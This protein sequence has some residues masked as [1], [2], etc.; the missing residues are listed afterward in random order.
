MGTPSSQPN[1]Q[2]TSSKMR[3]QC[4]I[5]YNKL[6]A[7]EVMP[8]RS[9]LREVYGGPALLTAWSHRPPRA[10]LS[11]L[12][13]LVQI[14]ILAD[15]TYNSLS[16]DEVAAAHIN[17]QC[18]IH[19]GR[20]SLTKLSRL[21]AFYVF[22]VE[23]LDTQEAARTLSECP[24]FQQAAD[25]KAHVVVFLDQIYLDS[26]PDLRREL[27]SRLPTE[28]SLLFAEVATRQAEPQPSLCC[29]RESR[30]AICCEGAVQSLAGYTWPTP[31][32]DGEVRYIWVGSRDAPALTQLQ[33]THNGAK[34]LSFYPES[35]QMV[36]GL[37]QDATRTL[38]RR[39]FLVEKARA[40]NI[41]GILVG[42]LGAAGYGD[43]IQQLRRA[44]QAAG[45]KTYTL[46]MGKP[47][48]AKLAN[49]PEIEVSGADAWY[50][51]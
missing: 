38:R 25:E 31:T 2:T 3:L 26:L 27:E 34:W 44:A 7:Q 23:P 11:F 28:T 32:G 12:P 47:S 40:A 20:A 49:F 17:A 1:S 39:Y 41:V 14:Y 35:H 10:F 50:F 37:S 22:P 19:Y 16:V 48:P 46:L 18:V 33:L 5:E 51:R 45:K 13:C 29:S 9:G 24:F 30:G 43:A 15:T 6:V 8:Y 4:A 36:E 42:T 21:P